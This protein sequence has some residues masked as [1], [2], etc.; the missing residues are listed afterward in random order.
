[1]FYPS[2]T[3][4]KNLKDAP[5]SLKSNP[6]MLF[7]ITIFVTMLMLGACSRSAPPAGD[8]FEVAAEL[9][10]TLWA[11]E[12]MLVNPTNFDIDE[13]GRIWLIES[14]NYRSDLWSRPKNDPQGDRI[15]I[16]EDTNGDGQADSRKIFDQH[17]EMLAPLGIS[18]LGKPG[19]CLPITGHHCLYQE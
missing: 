1:M 8:A 6:T 17:A 10:L 15:V 19:D 9:E 16:L 11:S 14:V 4:F 3:Q 18:V 13:R 2:A 12:P 7:R 5:Q